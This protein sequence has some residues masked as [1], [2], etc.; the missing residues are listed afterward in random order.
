MM[1][2]NEILLEATRRYW[3]S[4]DIKECSLCDKKGY[5]VVHEMNV[6][7]EDQEDIFCIC[8]E[9][10]GSGVIFKHGESV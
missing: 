8:P 10:N 4:A 2:K 3:N 5:L 9:C 1:S 6:D 7:V